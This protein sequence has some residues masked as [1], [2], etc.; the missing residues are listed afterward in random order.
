MKRLP[1]V[2]PSRGC[3]EPGA[4]ALAAALA[5]RAGGGDVLR[6]AVACDR[7]TLKNAQA[8]AIPGAGGE[9]GA[10]LAA[11]L[12]ALVGDPAG[13]LEALRGV[14]E[15]DVARA[16][17]LIGSGAVAVGLRPL[18]GPPRL[19]VEARVA[20]SA[21]E[22]RALLEDAHTRVVALERDG[23]PVP[24]LLPAWVSAE[25]PRSDPTWEGW[26]LAD[27][28]ALADA[29]DPEDAAALLAALRTNLSAGEAPEAP[30]ADR[31]DRLAES[32]AGR[33]SRARMEGRPVT[34]VTSGFSGNQGLV[35]SVPV[36]ALA[37]EVGADESALARALAT[38]HL[39]GSYVRSFTGVLSPL[40][41]AVQAA[42]AGAA[43]GCVRLL[44][45]GLA[46]VER[47]CVD[48]LASVA[49]TLCDGAK[50]ACSL[51]VA[52][53]AG[54]AVRI[55]RRAVESS[56]PP[57]RDGIAGATL[58]E[59]ARNL[60]RLVHPA[61]AAVDAELLTIALAK[62]KRDGLHAPAE[63]REGRDPPPGGSDPDRV[64]G[65][66]PPPGP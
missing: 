40:C 47:A 8:P 32:V 65:G 1:G 48:V 34:V 64:R 51:K 26:A 31:A 12:G 18:D 53:G 59:T 2:Q 44:G 66:S 25:A 19:S 6:V 56:S 55:A 60:A 9:R 52:L 20:T 38:S 50:P 46:E 35:A 45:G 14:G 61:M 36:W 21:G 37:R 4:I 54:Q 41:N 30:G 58:E 39:V 27:V 57:S 43:A 15:E 63:E 42:S 7:N 24:E 17:R 33:G 29:L 11:A 22:G 3:T 62:A 16:R 5:S 28:V 10:E 23:V 49:G 13:G